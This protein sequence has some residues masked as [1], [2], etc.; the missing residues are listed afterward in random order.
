M[1]PSL[2]LTKK[3]KKYEEVL[4]GYKSLEH[5]LH[6]IKE[7]VS[8][9]QSYDKELQNEFK[10]AFKRKGVLVS[11][12]PGEKDDKNLRACCQRE[13][14]AELPAEHFFVPEV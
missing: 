10:K 3:I 13:V 7:L 14:D 8:Q 9:K 12:E 2:G 6:E 11:N 5:D 4:S 1:K